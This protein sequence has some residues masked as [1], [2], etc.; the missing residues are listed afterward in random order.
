MFDMDAWDRLNPFDQ[1]G[2]TPKVGGH[3]T[4][5]IAP[6]IA[7][8]AGPGVRDIGH[9]ASPFHPDNPIFWAIGLGALTLGLIAASTQIR[10]GKAK[11]SVSAGKTS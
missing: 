7:R 3:T 10:V 4:G 1:L 2:L 9:D 11:V 8:A 5:D 6:S